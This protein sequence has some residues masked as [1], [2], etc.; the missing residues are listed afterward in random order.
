M[1]LPTYKKAE[2]EALLRIIFL[3]K[4]ETFGRYVSKAQS[5]VTKEKYVPLKEIQ[6]RSKTI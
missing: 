5:S 6:D 1:Q 2:P 3:F 4:T